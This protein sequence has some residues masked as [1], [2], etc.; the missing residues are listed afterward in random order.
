METVFAAIN[1][2]LQPLAILGNHDPCEMAGALEKLGARVLVND[3]AEIRVRDA[4]L[5]FAGV[6]DSYDYRCDDLDAAL[7]VVPRDTF[8][9]LLAHTPDLY[10]KAAAAGMKLYLCGHTHAGQVRLPFIGSVIQNSTAPRAYT[11][12]PWKHGGMDGYTSA[13]IG[14]SMLPIR[15]GCPPEIVVI[16]LRRSVVRPILAARVFQAASVRRG[17]RPGRLVNA[18]GCAGL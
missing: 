10:A 1:S 8:N 9:I 18:H 12:G 15:F 6:D 11:H 4:S 3:A 2:R 7:S 14:C 16:D 5:W 17:F 13:G